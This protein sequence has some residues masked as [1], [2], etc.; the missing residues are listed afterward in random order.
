MDRLLK[1]LPSTKRQ[2][3]GV[4]TKGTTVRVLDLAIK[5]LK[6][7]FRDKLGAF[8]ILG[9]PVLM[10]LFFGMVMSGMSSGN[11]GKMEAV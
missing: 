11:Q 8:F 9:F 7:L 5:D 2:S 4:L 3:G 1:R 6:L 10:G